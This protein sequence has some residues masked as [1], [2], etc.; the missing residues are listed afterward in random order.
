MPAEAAPKRKVGI[1]ALRTAEDPEQ[2]D[3]RRENA[4]LKAQNEELRHAKAAL[5]KTN[6]QLRMKLERLELIFESQGN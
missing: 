1:S 4:A 3:L 2:L 6:E 5:A